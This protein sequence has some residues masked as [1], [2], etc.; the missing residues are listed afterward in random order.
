MSCSWTSPVGKR[1]VDVPTVEVPEAGVPS[2]GIECEW[3]ESLI[4][5][6]TEYDTKPDGRKGPWSAAKIQQ[7][8]ETRKKNQ[9]LKKARQPHGAPTSAT[10]TP[11]Q[12]NSNLTAEKIAMQ[13][14][15]QG[16]VGQ[17]SSPS[18]QQKRGAPA[19]SGR[20]KR[21]NQGIP[22]SRF[23]DYVTDVDETGGGET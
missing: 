17:P 22:A 3:H 13:P 5:T 7:G 16:N 10:R 15:G 9:A 2:S 21:S 6:R 8:R 23:D 19:P 18:N 11:T 1:L 20:S 4:D 14:T 12:G